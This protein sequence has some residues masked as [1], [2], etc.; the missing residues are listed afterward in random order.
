MNDKVNFRTLLIPTG[1]D[2][3]EAQNIPFKDQAITLSCPFRHHIIEVSNAFC[4]QYFRYLSESIMSLFV[5]IRTMSDHCDSH[6][7]LKGPR[8]RGVFL[9]LL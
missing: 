9:K 4:V 3:I 7:A 5:H 2:L 6:I 1:D 8:M